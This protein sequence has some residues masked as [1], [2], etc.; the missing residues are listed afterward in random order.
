VTKVFFKR[1]KP[2]TSLKCA[3][4]QRGPSNVP[5]EKNCPQK[6]SKKFSELCPNQKWAK[7]IPKGVTLML[8][9]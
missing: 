3:L 5:K 2:K 7:T 6:P 4:D 9:P 1:K 8:P